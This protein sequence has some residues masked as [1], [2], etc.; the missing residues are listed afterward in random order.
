MFSFTLYRMLRYVLEDPQ[1]KPPT[2]SHKDSAGIDLFSPADVTIL[3]GEKVQI[4]LGVEFHFPPGVGGLLCLREN[5]AKTYNISLHP[6][7]V[8]MHVLVCNSKHYIY[9]FF[10]SD[11]YSRGPIQVLIR[12][13]ERAT[14][15]LSKDSSWFQ[16]VPFLLYT[17]ELSADVLENDGKS[18]PRREEPLPEEAPESELAESEESSSQNESMEE[19]AGAAGG[20][21]EGEAAAE[22]APNG[23]NN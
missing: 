9:L 17:G 10:S 3:G 11:P 22:E 1:A 19:D 21:Q 14:I 5:V 20:G 12:S 13:S 16:L 7:V 6:A 23:G 4:N 18:V 8:G 15:K 2:R